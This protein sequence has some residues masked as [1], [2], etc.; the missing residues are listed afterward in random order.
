MSTKHSKANSLTTGAKFN[1]GAT[2]R[3]IYDSDNKQGQKPLSS[4]KHFN[5]WQDPKGDHQATNAPQKSQWTHQKTSNG[6]P[7]SKLSALKSVQ[8]PQTKS[9]PKISLQPTQPTVTHAVAVS[10]SSSQ[11]THKQ[12]D[13]A[14]LEAG[15]PTPSFL[16]EMRKN[17]KSRNADDDQV[18]VSSEAKVV[19]DKNERKSNVPNKDENAVNPAT[20]VK[21]DSITATN[22]DSVN[23]SNSL[24]DNVHIKVN[25]HSDGTNLKNQS[26]SSTTSVSVNPETTSTPTAVKSKL[27]SPRH[28][29][30]AARRSRLVS[31]TAASN[32]THSSNNSVHSSPNKKEPP[33]P[34]AKSEASSYSTKS[35]QRRERILAKVRANA[36][37][38]SSKNAM[39]VNTMESRISS[40]A[41][42]KKIKVKSP[43]HAEEVEMLLAYEG[44]VS[45]GASSEKDDADFGEIPMIRKES[46]LT[47]DSISREVH[48]NSRSSLSLAT[49]QKNQGTTKT[50]EGG[51][52][53][54][55]GNTPHKKPMTQQERLH[56]AST[57]K[58][59][60]NYQYRRDDFQEEEVKGGLVNV[61]KEVEAKQPNM[62]EC[63]QE[64]GTMTSSTS[65]NQGSVTPN[66]IERQ[67][68]RRRSTSGSTFNASPTCNPS[69]Q[70]QPKYLNHPD[71]D[72]LLN[73]AYPLNERAPS[74]I[75]A[76]SGISIP[77]CF[78]PES[79][80]GNL[81]QPVL[82]NTPTNGGGA[83][84]SNHSWNGALFSNTPIQEATS[85]NSG[86]SAMSGGNL[87]RGRN[88]SSSSSNRNNPI[89]SPRGNSNG[90]GRSA[91]SPGVENENRRLREQIGGMQKKLEEKDAI[92]SQLMKRIGDLENSE[93]NKSS[94]VRSY[95]MDQDS[96]NMSLLW[97]HSRPASDVYATT[98]HNSHRS[99]S[100]ELQSSNFSPDAESFSMPSPPHNI[101]PTTTNV[102]SKQSPNTTHTSSTASVTTAN[103]G[104]SHQRGSSS[105]SVPGQHSPANR[106]RRSPYRRGNASVGGISNASTI[107][108]D[109][110]DD[111]RF[112]C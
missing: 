37:G 11:S 33:S 8:S 44:S 35:T 31:R 85:F 34:G 94:S 59:R 20:A 14:N 71:D 86:N 107:G 4:P 75:S 102:K 70:S 78:P 74:T 68:Q 27:T 25:P 38:S 96:Y 67:K 64:Q 32:A 29:D 9:S 69:P 90:T 19:G 73:D 23:E 53:K 77:S 47:V 105:R 88:S 58:I 28:S 95:S 104:K 55:I 111:R 13:Q 99:P 21:Q 22:Q 15:I 42:S 66:A 97:D 39:T 63:I 24:G 108:S 65:L 109:V 10:S 2:S 72:K 92:I 48:Q 76:I 60:G 43:P 61:K 91:F 1:S 52:H 3:S 54:S 30:L 26:S 6:H 40:P 45:G 93:S 82:G 46:T 51:K 56:M 36:T 12:W 101:L 49:A 98:I 87:Q 62:Q 18:Q 84:N 103:S 83:L 17:L 89:S 110:V 106:T 41:L 7:S 16:M 81:Q 80:F 57:P 50:E 79:S 112:Q 5:S 100:K